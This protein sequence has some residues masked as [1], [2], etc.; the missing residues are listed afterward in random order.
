MI[1][2]TN[3]KLLLCELELEAS[4]GFVIMIFKFFDR[5]R[6]TSGSLRFS[7]SIQ[8]FDFLKIFTNKTL[9]FFTPTRY[10]SINQIF[11]KIIFESNINLYSDIR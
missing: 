2:S 4:F 1:F 8:V 6:R 10:F 7:N 5:Y 9:R 3:N 11:H